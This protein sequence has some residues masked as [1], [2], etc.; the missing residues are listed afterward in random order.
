LFC[1]GYQPLPGKSW[2]LYVDTGVYD[3]FCYTEE[4]MKRLLTWGLVIWLAMLQGVA[5]LLHAHVHDLSSPGKI[6]MPNLEI[7]T[8]HMPAESGMYMMKVNLAEED[9]IG[10]ESVGENEL[11][12]SVMDVF[13]LVAIILFALLPTPSLVW[14]NLF[15]IPA[16]FRTPAYALPWSLAPP[17]SH[18]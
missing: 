1:A 13:L 2:H 7:D 8:N 5:P 11:D 3:V 6:H 4:M 14:T 10:M 15:R 9:A 16:V 18:V 17:T 12:I